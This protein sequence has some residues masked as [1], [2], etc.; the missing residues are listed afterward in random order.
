MSIIAFILIFSIVVVAHEFG[1][2][3]LAK[4][5]GIRVVEFSVGMGPTLLHFTKGETK[6]SLKLLPI[7]GAC[8]YEGED[9]IYSEE[10]KENPGTSGSFQSAG[11]WARI[12]SVVAGPIFNLI[13]AFLL[14]MI[15]VGFSGTDVPVVKNTIPDFPAQEA[16]LMA[17][18]VITAI[19]GESIHLYREVTLATLVNQ[20]KEMTVEYDRNGQSHSATITPK[21]DEQEGRYL[22]GIQ[23]GEVKQAKGFQLFQYSYYEVLYWLKSTFK[24]LGMLVTGKVTVNDL[25]GPVGIAVVI[26]DA[27]EATTPYGMST[28][29]LTMINIAILLSV[30]LGVL[31]LLPLPA[32]DGGRLV[33]LLL[34]AVRG[35]PIPQEREGMIHFVG[36]VALMLLMAVV[37]FNDIARIFR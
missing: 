29:L 3:L 4:K 26:D 17:G 33:F 7:G 37:M 12:S 31:N 10:G 20:G 30:N 6:Y 14:S 36:F 21:M 24:S 34:E 32:L 23:G 9:G 35:K 11:V 2:F 28:V 25:S 13:L 8:M 19:N 15:V 1:H 16:G 27:I 18:D 5:N 22:F